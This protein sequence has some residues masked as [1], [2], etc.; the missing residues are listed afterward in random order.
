MEADRESAH[1]ESASTV[2]RR[3][4]LAKVAPLRRF[5]LR[6]RAFRRLSRR[7][8]AVFVPALFLTPVFRVVAK[9]GGI[10]SA[11]AL[12][13]RLGGKPVSQPS[14]NAKPLKIAREVVLGVRAAA[15]A[16]PVELVCLPRSLASWTILNRMGVASTLRIGMDASTAHRTAHAWIDVAGEA[17]GEVPTHIAQMADFADPILGRKP[18]P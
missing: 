13:S 11:T 1:S 10:K 14:D 6:V 2:V 9:R 4:R 8:K 12:A 18:T 17:V 7:S 5:R 16:L 3:R 15:G